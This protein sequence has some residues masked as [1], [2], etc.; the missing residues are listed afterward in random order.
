MGFRRKSRELALQM[1]FLL[2]VNK[3]GPDWRK[4]F[5]E[6][7]PAPPDVAAF[8]DRLVD[9]VLDHQAEIDRLI[10]KHALHWTLNR[11]SIVDRNILRCAVF[12]LLV[13]SDVPAK[14]TMNEAIEIA[15]R[16]SDAESGAFVN[17]ILDHIV[18]EESIAKKEA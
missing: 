2:D 5:W 18:R 12:E 16:Y 1:L 9:G 3:D 10:Q 13:L 4:Q 7:H 17:G 15:K 11:M 6:L 14:V 8:A